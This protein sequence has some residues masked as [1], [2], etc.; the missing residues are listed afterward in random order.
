MSYLVPGVMQL[1]S[2]R[3]SFG[4]SSPRSLARFSLISA[5]FAD[6]KSN[7]GRFH[8]TDNLVKWVKEKENHRIQIDHSTMGSK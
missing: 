6:L 3:A 8:L 5:S 4:N 7:T 1:E 2:N